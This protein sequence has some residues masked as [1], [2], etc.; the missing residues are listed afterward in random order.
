MACLNQS[1][2]P[3]LLVVVAASSVRGFIS[4]TSFTAIGWSRLDPSSFHHQTVVLAAKEK[5]DFDSSNSNDTVV[6]KEMF[7]R[8]LLRDPNDDANEDDATNKPSDDSEPT[9]TVKRKKGGKNSSNSKHKNNNNQG[10]KVLDNRDRLP[11]AV[12]VASP[13]P[14]TH[15][16]KKKHA[17]RQ[18][19][20]KATHKK[21]HD[22]IEAGIASS[23][24]FA[25]SNSKKKKNNKNDSGNNN[26]KK[27]DPTTHLGDFVLD[28]LT[29]TGDLLEINDKQYQ[30]VQ[31]RCQYKYAGGK[32]FVMVRKILQVK[33]VGRI[34]TEEYLKAQ[35]GRNVVDESNVPPEEQV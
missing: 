5:P 31:H 12:R 8:E 33:E 28:K 17:A 27:I 6:T 21:R 18:Q 19:S 20:K 14:Y 23:L 35:F 1:F 26:N 30:V 7:L 24:Y 13:D 2:L 15:P 9:V 10:Y 29:T 32:R 3:L 11:F 4:S 22:A 25:P 16:D 34:Q